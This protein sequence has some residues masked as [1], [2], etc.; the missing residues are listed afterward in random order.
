MA[1]QEDDMPAPTAGFMARQDAPSIPTTAPTPDTSPGALA[2]L[3]RGGVEAWHAYLAEQAQ[4]EE[5]P[6]DQA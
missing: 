6:D 5:G 4:Q 1:E 3:R 2:A